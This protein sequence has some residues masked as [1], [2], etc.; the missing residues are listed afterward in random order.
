MAC[1]DG[2]CIHVCSERIV[3]GKNTDCLMVN[4]RPVCKCKPG[5]TG[6]P[7]FF[8]KPITGSISDQG[9]SSNHA[10]KC[11]SNNECPGYLACIK[12]I[13]I[14]LCL[15]RVQCG[16]DA[17][18][19]ML[20]HE[21]I[22]TCKEG[23]TG[24]PLSFCHLTALEIPSLCP[25]NSCGPNTLCKVVDDK[26]SCKCLPNYVGNPWT[27]CR[28][29]CRRHTECK[30][31]EACVDHICRSACKLCGKN[32]ICEAVNNH[33]P[34]CKCP[35]GYFGNPYKECVKKQECRSNKDCP[36]H[37]P[38]CKHFECENP[39]GGSCGIN[40][41][42]IIQ[43]DQGYCICPEF[44]YGNPHIRC[45]APPCL[46]NFR[47][48]GNLACVNDTCI[49]TCRT[50]PKCGKNARC[51]IQANQAICLC[52]PGFTGDPLISCKKIANP[53]R[54]LP[55]SCGPNAKCRIVSG[56]ITCQCL[57]KHVGNPWIGCRPGCAQHD[58][59]RENEACVAQTCRSA[60]HLCGKDAMCEGVKNHRPICRCPPGYRGNPYKRCIKQREC[61]KNIDCPKNKPICT[62]YECEN[63]CTNL[64]GTN[65]LCRIIGDQGVCFCRE[66]YFGNPNIECRPPPCLPG[67]RCPM[68][69]ACV[70]GVCVDICSKTKK[71][72]KNAACRIQDNKPVCICYPGFTGDPLTICK[73]IESPVFCPPNSCGP[74]TQCEVINKKIIC[75]CLPKFIGDPWKGCQHTCSNHYDCR[76]KE[77]CIGGICQDA[78]K[79][80]GKNSMCEELVASKPVCICRPGFTG[81]PYRECRQIG[82]CVKNS[83]CP[84]LKP[85]CKEYKCQNPCDRAC[86]VGAI[87]HLKLDEAICSC[88]Y[89]YTGDPLVKC[90][91]LEQL[92]RVSPCGP[93]TKCI[94]SAS[95]KPICKCLPNFFGN[96]WQGCFKRCVNHRECKKQEMCIQSICR[97][98][99]KLCGHKAICHRVPWSKPICKCPAGFNGDPYKKCR[100]IGDCLTNADCP[101][102]KPIC[103]QFE[104]Q[105]PCLGACGIDAICH[106]EGVKAVCTCPNE[107]TGDPLVKCRRMNC[108]H[109]HQCKCTADH[110]CPETLSCV[111]QICVDLCLLGKK[112]GRNALCQMR[113]HK[114]ICICSPGLTGDPLVNCEPPCYSQNDCPKNFACKN[115]ICV[116]ICKKFPKCGRNAMCKVMNNNAVCLCAP[117]FT[118]NPFKHCKKIEPVKR[119]IKSPCGPNTICLLVNRKPVCKCLPNYVGNPWKGCRQTCKIHRNCK[120]TEICIG[121]ICQDACLSCGIKAICQRVSW[122]EPICKCPVGYTGNPRKECRPIG[123]CITNVDC[124]PRK[125]VCKQFHCQNPCIGA[126]GIDALCRIQGV[127]PICTCPQEFTGDPLV[128]CKRM[129][130]RHEHECK[131]MEDHD[132]PVTLS[133][134]N[135][136]CVDLCFL[137]KRCGKNAACHM[138]HHK[139]V[140]E[141]EPGLIG[142]PLIKCEPPC[143]SQND[144]APNWACKDKICVDLCRTFRK[145]GKNALCKIINNEP[146]CVCPPGYQGNPLKNCRIIQPVKYC[147]RSPCGP[148]TICIIVRGKPFCRCLPNYYGNPWKGCLQRCRIHSECKMKEVCIDSVCQDACTLCGKLAI[149]E[150]VP[151]REPVCKCPPGY[152]GNAFEGCK[153]IGDCI[154]NADCPERKPVCKKYRCQNPCIGA[155]GIDALCHIKDSEAV[156]TCPPEFTGDPL[157]KC[158]RINCRHE[159]Q[160]RCTN[161]YDCPET[162]SCLRGICVDLCLVGHKCGINA[163]CQMR[164][165]K[166]ICVCEPGLT[167]D[168]LS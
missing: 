118:G 149:C 120:I 85:V 156:C 138:R 93:N 113:K 23:Y 50:S 167:G 147:D 127:K 92:C 74:N 112:C 144:C 105:N 163:V 100:Q 34:V 27:G 83:D 99:C 57:P 117:G 73:K 161:D 3:C 80:C 115:N 143:Y 49:D 22:C 7:N 4:H 132:C 88:P 32:A 5:F 69:L 146:T 9:C 136:V 103:K 63:P 25:P 64:C 31:N 142:N 114:A 45:R 61:S 37:K 39:C 162:L 20:N 75:K 58:D 52:D 151:W 30:D 135:G 125:P 137:G 24:D 159:H 79:L 101:P 95:S 55:N 6:N 94:I 82:D 133:C 116:D 44:Y 8:C 122:N 59:C 157:I 65:A 148:N 1:V 111:N 10:C 97:D 28:L 150:R 139:A 123:D 54:C 168:P 166:A 60:C 86:G 155:C 78:C 62:N 29:R 53:N 46:P 87:C 141:C 154:T 47:C 19:R 14:D 121:N 90:K 81:N 35:T 43:G 84:S 106:I 91:L 164:Q 72:G 124:P 98:S 51:R 109:D 71:C 102:R 128:K 165:R 66:F 70:N 26:I 110:D 68:N 158:R 134:V 119:C 38:V 129:N 131:C 145:C 126:C 13:C 36:K 11:S 40:A 140:C 48:P 96:P 33:R 67:D 104:C 42:C 152:T 12:G 15:M 76:E 2:S 130:C 89:G 16:R 41:L 153:K 160:C 77:A 108:R 107:Y 21:A 18:C 56:K 17:I